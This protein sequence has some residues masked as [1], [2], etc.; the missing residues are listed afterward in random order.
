MVA[1]NPREAHRLEI[2]STGTDPTEPTRVPDTSIGHVRP[3]NDTS[4]TDYATWRSP[5]T[6]YSLQEKWKKKLK[7]KQ[8][9]K[10]QNT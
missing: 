9:T 8:R 10:H 5:E 2:N 1:I 3:S 4:V 7:D 6:R